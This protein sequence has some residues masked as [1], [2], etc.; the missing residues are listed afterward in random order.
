MNKKNKSNIKT[1]FAFHRLVSEEVSCFSLHY[2][3]M[4]IVM[5]NTAATLQQEY[6]FSTGTHMPAANSIKKSVIG[7]R[8]EAMEDKGNVVREFKIGNTRIKICDNAYRD[9]TP[10]DVEAILSRIAA[11]AQ[12]QL[13][14][15][16]YLAV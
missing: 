1:D 7:K 5:I 10:S 16:V 4:A 14:A 6:A 13:T 9:K 3:R 11:R 12:E 15:Q 8:G 2:R